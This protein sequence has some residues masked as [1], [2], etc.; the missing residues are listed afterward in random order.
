M[1]LKLIYYLSCI[2]K[3]RKCYFTNIYTLTEIMKNCLPIGD[4]K[5]L[6]TYAMDATCLTDA[7]N[8]TNISDA[9]CIMQATLE[10]R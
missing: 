2:G 1:Q 5:V 4:I 8:I 7:I 10:I 3:L 6:A 9:L